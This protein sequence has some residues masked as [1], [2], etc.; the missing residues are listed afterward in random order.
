ML[1]TF[2]IKSTDR[3]HIKTELLYALAEARATRQGLLCLRYTEDTQRAILDALLPPLKRNKSLDIFLHADALD[4]PS[5]EA[6]FLHNKYEVQLTE[7]A[8]SNI[9][10]Y[11]IHLLVV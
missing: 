2:E 4:G 3:A 6:I 5:T 10:Y 7:A 1:Y 11:I 9:P 8:A